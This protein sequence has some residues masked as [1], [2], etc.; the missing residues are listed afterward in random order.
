M[1]S[2]SIKTEP[3]TRHSTAR[4]WLAAIAACL[5]AP[6]AS[7]A[8]G[9]TT[10]AA[11]TAAAPAN[12]GSITANGAAVV[13]TVSSPNVPATFTFAGTSGEIVTA[14]ASGG[15]FAGE[16][17][18][19]LE[20]LSP[21]GSTVASG[22]CAGQS[23]FTGETALP[24]AATYTLE[25]S[26]ND[27]N[28]GSVTL[29]LSANPAN[30][31]ITANGAKVTFTA[32]HTAQ[33]KDFTFAGQAGEVVTVSAA[34]G[35]FLS[36]CDLQLQLLDPAGNAIGNAGCMAQSGFLAE[37]V[38]PSA[39]TYT[40]DVTPTGSDPG[41]N[42]GKVSL[43]LS[44]DPADGTITANGAPVT[45]TA[46][47]TGQGQDFTFTG[48]A[49]EVVTLS[50]AGGTFLSPCDLE[51]QLLDGA[52]N[53]IGNA[54][55]MAQTGFF[56]ETTLPGA[57]TY[58]VHVTPTGG[59]PGANTGSV[60]LWLS[61]DSAHGTIKANGTPVTFTAGHTAQGRDFTFTGKAGEVVTVSAS[62]GTFL[63][64]CDLEMQLLTSSGHSIGN[65]G[66]TAQSGFIAETPL[67]GAGTY[68]IR[69]TPTGS[70][71]GANT[72]SVTLSLSS[73]PADST[74]SANGA[75]VTFTASHTGQGQDFT[76]SGT[77][78][79][80]ISMTFSNGT[81]L[82]D[83]DLETQILSPSGSQVGNAGCMAQSG[84]LADTTLPGTG[85][86]TVDVTPTGAD[87]GANT[88][89]VKLALASG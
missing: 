36:E 45:F 75:P 73:D 10:A 15:T 84:S 86:Y 1:T 42:T 21:T 46:G 61:S 40:V 69:V 49:G 76:F 74:I 7:L 82:S 65:G 62:G 71:P 52:G 43:W 26:P 70:D 6:A 12:S 64:A 33:G 68:T 83:C 59:D 79:E 47:H 2:N 35:T 4:R 34:G 77:A 58:T 18:V 67:P 9:A 27:G 13:A 44:A 29:R 48:T 14:S 20:I 38:L 63:S 3:T 5:I 50:A 66:C 55:C 31:K 60:T 22:G 19:N 28:L 78:G 41:A 89:S 17:D 37:T 23:G 11:A 81:F 24:G 85:T 16:C 25:L 56:G 8:I 39:G 30:G 32:S 87:P 80:V 54:G 57:G 51:T 53:A 88:G 72:G